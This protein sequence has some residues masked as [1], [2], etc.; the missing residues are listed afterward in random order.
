MSKKNSKRKSPKVISAKQLSI[1]LAKR[2]DE[3]KGFEIIVFDLQ[4]VSP[5]TDYFVIANGLSDIHNRT[6]ADDLIE[7]EKPEH[8]EGFEEGKWVLLDFIDVI[9]HIFS[10]ETREFYGLERLWGDA[11]QVD[12]DSD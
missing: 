3:K 7:Y 4:G 1:N 6:I 11:P 8:I 2:I 10:E 9:V 12:Y 5:I